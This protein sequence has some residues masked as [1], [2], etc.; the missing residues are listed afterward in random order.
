MKQI[1]IFLVALLACFSLQAQVP[2]A[3]L[4]GNNY[5]A[6]MFNMFCDNFTKESDTNIYLLVSSS[7]D[8][9]NSQ[10]TTFIIDD[11]L[12]IT[13]CQNPAIYDSNYNY[14]GSNINAGNINFQIN[15]VGY[16]FYVYN[17]YPFITGFMD[18]IARDTISINYLCMDKFN[19]NGT[20]K[21]IDTVLNLI[22]DSIK[23]LYFQVKVLKNNNILICLADTTKDN[24]TELSHKVKLIE[25]DTLGNV[26]KTKLINHLNLAMDVCEVNDTTILLSI[27]G[28][29]SINCIAGNAVIY[30]L[31]RNTF[32][33]KDSI[34][35]YPIEFMRRLTDDKVFAYC[36][37][38]NILP[39][40]RDINVLN[41]AT[42]TF[43]SWEYQPQGGYYIDEDARQ[44]YRYT[45]DAHI[46]CDFKNLDSIYA[47]YY[48]Y[49]SNSNYRSV[50]I[51]NFS[52]NGMDT[53]F[54]FRIGFDTIID[55]DIKIIKATKDGGVIFVFLSS[56][57]TS[58]FYAVKF[59]PNG[60]ASIR[61][62]TTGEKESIR[63]YPVPAKDWVCVQIESKNIGVGSNIS[64]Y[65]MSGE[66][67]T[68][69]ALT[70]ADTK[71][72]VS[73]LA[74]GAYTYAV[75][76]NGKSLSGKLIIQ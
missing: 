41:I 52:L 74:A 73:S 24:I 60:F 3:V 40:I 43:Y 20:T 53:N 22:N 34:N 30:Y 62:L 27:N 9:S 35:G 75:V 23:W 51:L 46:I 28:G 7:K 44:L 42:K 36:E 29:N 18:N 76:L 15:N 1:T 59:M 68:Q 38:G 16:R 70:K 64:I 58:Y 47:Y 50:G 54:S 25:I 65:N 45:Q 48:L 6:K 17:K 56:W 8:H 39:T 2:D 19:L 63:V 67:A 5:K 26:I 32:D 72:N 14:Y 71:I 21:T 33:I 4:Y 66:L 31:D 49:N 55:K 61:D 69:Q 12:N 11:S 10:S 57:S 13:T 37:N